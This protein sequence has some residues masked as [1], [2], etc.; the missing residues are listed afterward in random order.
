MDRVAGWLHIGFRQIGRGGEMTDS[1]KPYL[2][3]VGAGAMG[4]LFGGLLR[5][6]GLDVTLID[7]KRDHIDAIKGDGLKIVG[8][9]GDR[10]IPIRATT[11]PAEAGVADVVIVF[12]KAMDTV[13]AVSDARSVFGD[14]T[15]AISFQNGLGNE[16]AICGV[17]GAERVLGGLTAQGATVLEPGVVRNFSDLPSYIGEMPGGLSQRCEQIAGAFSRAGLD[18]TA[19]A[20]I[21]RDIWK[22]LLANVSLSPVSGATN[23]NTREIMAIPEVKAMSL[24][25]LEEAAQVARA[26]GID[27]S[28]TEKS[29]VL[30]KIA[31][32]G[33]T[34]EAKSSLCVDL[35]NKRPCEIDFIN[36]S[37]VRL[38]REYGVPTPVNDTL[39]AV[40]KGVQSHYLK[41]A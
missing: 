30:E 2:V 36:G 17:I 21:R 22:K 8:Y 15:V 25:A 39:V 41:P 4:G 13:K 35:L 26:V 24:A 7:I 34:P 18:T 38:G 6:G 29:A 40:V 31:G 37:I 27:L 12:T 3:V 9:G 1:Y 20:D 32:K 10:H 28:D 33:G 11:D 19:S 5:E 23:L 16:E 14:H